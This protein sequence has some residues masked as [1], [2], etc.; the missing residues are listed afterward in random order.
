[1]DSEIWNLRFRSASME[2]H[3][4][5]RKSNFHL[6]FSNL[7]FRFCIFR[8][9]LP[10]DRA[11]ESAEIR[12]PNAVRPYN[13]QLQWG[14]APES[15]E[16]I[17]NLESQIRPL[18]FSATARLTAREATFHFPFSTFHFR[19]DSMGSKAKS[20]LASAQGRNFTQAR[21]SDLPRCHSQLPGC[22]SERSE[23]SRPAS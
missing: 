2:S 5:T 6:L 11:P 7:H 15:A 13:G 22:H 1:M 3:A 21:H 12:G 19:L 20:D 14:R 18:C 4:R 23:E 8:I 9:W 16:I 10:C 17:S